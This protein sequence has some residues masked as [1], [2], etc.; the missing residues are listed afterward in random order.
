M[1]DRLHDEAMSKQLSVNPGYAAQLLADVLREGSLAEL[2]ILLR[3]I[4]LAVGAC[5]QTHDVSHPITPDALLM[6]L[7]RI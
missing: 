7:G 4:T 1:R 5:D 6:S 3:Q 2:V